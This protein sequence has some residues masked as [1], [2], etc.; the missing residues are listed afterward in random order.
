[1]VKIEAARVDA[2]HCAGHDLVFFVS[3]WLFFVVTVYYLVITYIL[4]HHT[5]FC[6]YFGYRVPLLI[7]SFI[8]L[9]ILIIFIFELFSDL[10]IF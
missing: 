5:V 4:F 2:L 9:F 10:S 7:Y 8:Y 3:F 1:M 6:M